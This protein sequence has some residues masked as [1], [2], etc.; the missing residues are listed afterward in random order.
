VSSTKLSTVQLHVKLLLLLIWA[1][2]RMATAADPVNFNRDI[3]P[4][5]SENCFKCHGPDENAR[6]GK[7]R[8]D[9]KDGAFELRDGKAAVVAN[10]L[11]KSEAYVRIVSEDPDDLMPPPKSNLKLTSVETVLI[12][13]WI[14]E[15]ATWA[16][17]WS[18]EKPIRPKL[19]SVS[20]F[21]NL[22]QN[23]IDNFIFARLVQEGL[24]P[25]AEA[26]RETL[27]RRVT[28]DLTGLPPTSEEV[29]R[30]MRDPSPN[31][32]ENLVDRLLESP[33]FGERMAWDWLDAARYADSNGY[34][35]DSDR[36]MWPWRDWV[37]QA[38]NQ[39]MP[40]DQF[41]LWQLAGDLLP[42]ATPEQKLATGFSRNHMINGEGGRIPEE[43]RVEYVMDMT[44]TAA[45][46]WL[47]LTFNCNRCHDHKFDPLSQR[48]YYSLSAFFNQTPV[49]GSGGNP[50]T[51]PALE[52]PTKMQRITLA[53]LN[54]DVQAVGKEVEGFEKGLA[55][56]ESDPEKAKKELE[57]IKAILEKAPATRSKT[58]IADLEK[59]SGEYF[60][61][62]QQLRETI[63]K[64]DAFRASIPKVM[65]ME[66]RNKPRETYM[67][68]R[69][70]YDKRGATVS[71]AT[72][73]KLPGFPEGAPTNRLGLALWLVSPDNPLTARVT[74]NRFWQQFFGVGLVKTANDFGV[75]GEKPSHPELLDWLA[76]EFVESGWDVK[77][78]CRLMLTSAT[79][80]QSS[81]ARPDV[82]EKDP[83]NRLLARA[84]RYRWPS[85]MLRD[86]ALAAAGLLVKR[87]G[88][89]SVKPYQ[90]AG[91]WEDATFGGKKYVSDQGEK[92]YRRSVYTFWR[93]IIAPTMFFDT[94][95]RQVCTVKQPRTNTPLHALALLNDIT[96]V[97]AARALAERVLSTATTDTARI[98]LAFSEVLSRLPNQDEKRA[99]QSS[100]DRLQKEYS[101]DPA[102]AGKLLANGESKPNENLNPTEFAAYTGLCLAI[103]NL[104]ETLTKE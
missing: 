68:E 30:F 92:L 102:A 33:A 40:Y 75:Q 73:A 63:E 77:E 23:P 55:S 62:L 3:R 53:K 5:L 1:L 96:Y 6:K 57:K 89:P 31:A 26:P 42:D 14:E 90:P 86:Q 49:D 37:V 97:E 22:V 4:I 87:V 71:A 10:D 44:E 38:F 27:I 47:G 28:L 61:K 65:V 59:Q 64:R 46:V 16:A 34:Q 15:G 13:R 99:L 88:G 60:K 8:L 74:V 48:D 43:N 78:L 19:P 100:I 17:H 51:P 2:S 11:S 82:T 52:W 25:S 85:W 83:E 67:L 12:K 84:P 54:G 76:V 94:A 32:Y 29:D 93:R 72:P 36:T 66:D 56:S 58:E 91:V 20:D 81:K 101:G 24:S 103:L 79:Y 104:D 69:G 45:T 50:Q 18:F 7:V 9:T 39:N 41:T 95:S 70:L 80:R 35:G 21:S 98:E